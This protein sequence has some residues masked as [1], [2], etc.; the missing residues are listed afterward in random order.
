MVHQQRL[1]HKFNWNESLQIFQ[2]FKFGD[3]NPSCAAA[4]PSP[5]R[6]IFENLP[7]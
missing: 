7:L 6:H 1:Q 4:I 2:Q 5:M 3:P